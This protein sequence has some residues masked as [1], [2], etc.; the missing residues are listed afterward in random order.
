M[1][2]NKSYFG[3]E[4]YLW[5]SENNTEYKKC[6]WKKISEYFFFNLAYQ[7]C[8]VRKKIADDIIAL[9]IR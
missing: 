4:I 6:F 2:R 5:K 8:I 9:L 1:F 3:I 7:I